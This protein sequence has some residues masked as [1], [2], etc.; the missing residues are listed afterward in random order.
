M[1]LVNISLLKIFCLNRYLDISGNVRDLHA[2]GGSVLHEGQNINE[3]D[4]RLSL[5]PVYLIKN[6]DLFM[7]S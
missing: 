2:L 5:L 3:E 1:P 6:G 4:W 7:K